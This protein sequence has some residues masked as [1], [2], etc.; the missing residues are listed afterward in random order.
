LA[1]K[2]PERMEMMGKPVIL[3]ID[4]EKEF[5]YFFLKR[6]KRRDI[7]ASGVFSGKQALD[8]LSVN[9]VDVAVLDVLTPGMDGLETLKRIKEISPETEVILLTGHGS[10]QWAEQGMAL[11]AFD[12]ML[13]PF[14]LDDL[15][16]RITAAYEN[17][18]INSNSSGPEDI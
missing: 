1:F 2:R 10:V 3:L 7:E 8:F 6:L 11:G 13:K 14:R 5:V 17:K 9:D 18:R 4:D 16:Q 12:Y 15:V